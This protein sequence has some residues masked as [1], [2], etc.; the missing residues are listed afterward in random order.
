MHLLFPLAA[1]TLAATAAAQLRQ[2]DWDTHRSPSYLL[3]T[4]IASGDTGDVDGD[5]DLDL[6]VS[7]VLAPLSRTELLLY[8]RQAG[9]WQETGLGAALG[10]NGVQARIVITLADLDGDGDLDAALLV[11]S[12]FGAPTTR[13]T[14]FRNN[15]SGGF[16]VQGSQPVPGLAEALLAVG[17][18]DGDGDRD[19]VVAGRNAAGQPQPA[20]LLRHDGAFGFLAVAN[21]LPAT[22]V[23]APV[24]ADLDG[25]TD[26]DLL[27]VDAAGAVVGWTNQSGGFAGGALAAVAARHVVA[28]DLDGD[29]DQDALA[30]RSDGSTL[31]LRN[32]G[33]TFVPQAVS[34]AGTAAGQRP[35]LAD[36]DGDLDLDA[37]IVVDGALRV[38]RNG[39]P[40]NFTS[41]AVAAANVI[42]AGDANQDGIQDLL[43]AVTNRSL[44]VAYGGPGGLAFDPV[45]QRRSFT[46]LAERGFT[47]DVDDLDG[48]DRIDLV[49][50]DTNL[51]LVRRNL[52]AGA[53][54]TVP[55]AV[56]FTLPRVRAAD[57]DG[58]GDRDLVVAAGES[59][60]GLLVL[61]H[62]PG[63]TFTA[64]PQPGFGYVH[65]AGLA[66]LDGDQ[67]EDL[68]WSTGSSGGSGELRLLRSLG[69]GT[70][71]PP[72]TL[73]TGTAASTK[74]GIADF[75]GDQD[76]D[77]LVTVL[78][79]PC[80]VLLV[81]DGSGGFTVG[82]PCAAS[83]PGF[84]TTS[85]GIRLA[86]IDGD[87]DPDLFTG[88]YGDGQMF[89]NN[90]GS[91][92]PGQVIQGVF[93]ASL[94]KPWFADWDGDG[95]QDLLQLG[96]PP[97][98]WLNDG[99]GN[100]VNSGTTRV[101]STEFSA[102]GAADLDGDGDVDPVGVLGLST[103]HYL[104]HQRSASSIAVP[105]PGG[106]LQLRLAHDPG[107]ATGNTLG[108]PILTLAARPTP[109][110]VPGIGGT[111][112]IDMTTAVLLAPMVFPA[113]GGTGVAT[114]P[115]PAQAGL[116]GFDLY[117]QGLLLNTA[118]MFTPAVHERIL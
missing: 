76:L 47:E 43:F 25:D 106:Q 110:R 71:A 8:R 101:G 103:Q 111:L 65:L 70:F 80:N 13:F 60:G 59:A 26:L 27:V 41:E 32:T 4:S 97:Q 93:G 117:A 91:F 113:P 17:D 48:D 78:P 42:A 28:G 37:A 58:D 5:G 30:Q 72:V 96:G 16:L 99:S 116:L 33:T 61:R 85:V 34:T 23:T 40:A 54:S 2:F 69:A 108:I 73:L 29:G 18:A 86:D 52:G 14:T 68:L 94:L 66:D 19:V 98:L 64:V 36:L 35:L 56:P 7:R 112:Q 104:N 114:F 15:G 118:A 24:F 95:D 46:P 9:I 38:L 87:G 67:R 20:V 107:I 49:Q 11:S 88:G 55:V 75:D 77:L 44:A 1:L 102:A 109:L 57:L 115:V 84:W 81:N 10:G 51:V 74:P 21:G 12:E 31:V 6:M 50:Q 83:L 100:F 62:D 79:A 22:P 92:A 53:W 39:G 89:V 105:T 82:N 90:N 63:F 45:L 3:A